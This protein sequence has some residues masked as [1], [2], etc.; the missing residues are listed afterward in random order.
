MC[1]RIGIVGG[2]GVGVVVVRVVV[3]VVVGVGG[4]DSVCV[5]VGGGVCVVLLLVLVMVCSLVASMLAL[6]VV[7]GVIS[8]TDGVRWC[9]DVGDVVICSVVA[10]VGRVGLSAYR[11]CCCR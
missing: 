9:V 11:T 4:I 3:H 6:F 8:I 5:V 7:V 1:G 10:V 2:V